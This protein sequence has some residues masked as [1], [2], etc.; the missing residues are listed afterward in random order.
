MIRELRNTITKNYT[1]KL[2][3]EKCLDFIKKYKPNILENRDCFNM[4]IFIDECMNVAKMKNNI[5]NDDVYS[6]DEINQWTELRMSD[7]FFNR[8]LPSG[9]VRINEDSLKLVKKGDILSTGGGVYVVVTDVNENDVSWCNVCG[10]KLALEI[11]YGFQKFELQSCKT[12]FSEFF[13]V[14]TWYSDKIFLA[15][16]GIKYP[17]LQVCQS[18]GRLLEY[19]ETQ[20]YENQKWTCKA[21]N[22]EICSDCYEGICKCDWCQDE[23]ENSL[24]DTIAMIKKRKGYKLPFEDIIRHRMNLSKKAVDYSDKL[25][26]QMYKFLNRKISSFF[27]SN[28]L[29]E[30]ISFYV[31]LKNFGGDMYF[32]FM[33]RST[34][35]NNYQSANFK[36]YLAEKFE[37]FSIVVNQQDYIYAHQKIKV[38]ALNIQSILLSACVDGTAMQLDPQ[39]VKDLIECSLKYGRLKSQSK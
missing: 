28:N 23:C 19:E 38:L 34:G 37:N 25:E 13:N 2:T 27:K 20:V 7:K 22:R 4:S 11:K 10:L 8:E 35:E 24:D 9:W 3:Y 18:C 30:Q 16:S 17:S 14:Y 39:M 1:G 15:F 21:G 12:T 36:L 26:L 6:F 33:V 5:R 31:K 29:E 32:D